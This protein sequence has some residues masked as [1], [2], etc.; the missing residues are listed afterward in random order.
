MW[1]F[2]VELGKVAVPKSHK[3]AQATGAQ[4]NERAPAGAGPLPRRQHA[5]KNALGSLQSQ[6]WTRHVGMITV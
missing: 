4:H 1:H 6:T 5:G 2:V 3:E